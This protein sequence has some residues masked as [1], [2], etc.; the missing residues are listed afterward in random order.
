MDAAYGHRRTRIWPESPH[1]LRDIGAAPVGVRTS[2]GVVPWSGAAARHGAGG[3]L[4]S[5]PGGGVPPPLP[6][7]H[8]GPRGGG[9]VLGPG[10]LAGDWLTEYETR[11]NRTGRRSLG[12]RRIIQN[13]RKSRGVRRTTIVRAV[14]WVMVVRSSA[15]SRPLGRERLMRRPRLSKPPHRAP[16]QTT[17]PS[18]QP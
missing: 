2:G 13:Y 14:R 4:A 15:V 18:R 17:D 8:A 10:A 1:R 9:V 11:N 12:H 3:R 7:P 5:S 16:R 6:C